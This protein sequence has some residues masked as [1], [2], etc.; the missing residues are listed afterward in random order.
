MGEGDCNAD[1]E[2]AGDLVCGTDN[3][4]WG[5]GD[6]CCTVGEEQESNNGIAKVEDRKGVA[7]Q[8]C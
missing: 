1:S 8:N 7:I 5:D 6:D 4:P 2:C 3:C